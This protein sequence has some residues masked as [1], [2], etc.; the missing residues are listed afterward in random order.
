M[1]TEYPSRSIIITGANNGIGLA[2]TRSLL[3]M[4][5]CIAV[6]DLETDNL[7]SHPHPNLLPLLKRAAEAE[8]GRAALES[9]LA[10]IANRPYKS[11]TDTDTDTFTS[12]VPVFAKAFRTARDGYVP[13][14]S[15]SHEQR[16]HS[17]VIAENLRQQLKKAK[18]DDPQVLKVALQIL[19]QE[20]TEKIET[21]L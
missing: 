4:G 12:K 19:L 3:A 1:T 11:W 9:V 16:K 13:E 20:L 6:L 8:D 5:D 10:Y 7:A 2:M 17:R 14:A 18:T 15:L 21:K